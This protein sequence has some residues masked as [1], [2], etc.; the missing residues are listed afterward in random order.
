MSQKNSD[1]KAKDNALRF[2]LN[3]ALVLDLLLA[4]QSGKNYDKKYSDLLARFRD[5]KKTAEFNTEIREKIQSPKGFLANLRDYQLTGLAWLRQLHSLELGGILADDMGLGKTVQVLAHL[6]DLYINSVNEK[7]AKDKPS[8]DKKVP[9]LLVVP[10]S[11]IYN[12]Q[13]EAE[14]FSPGLKVLDYSQA[15]RKKNLRNF[16]SYHLI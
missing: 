9:S 13:K 7:Q 10:R 3:Q 14:R 4:E 12:W 16:S 5:L 2:G 11:L 8:K 15:D 6:H 1:Q